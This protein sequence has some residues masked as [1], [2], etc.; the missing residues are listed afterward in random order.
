MQLIISGRHL[1]VTDEMKAH[2]EN[3]L[4]RL[5]GEYPK[6]TTGRVVMDLERNWHV[7]EAHIQGKHVNFDASARTTDMYASIDDAI[8]KLE[9]QLRRYLDRVQ[10]HH[11]DHGAEKEVREELAEAV[12]AEAEGDEEIDE[13]L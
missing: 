8:G 7:V 5:A 13:S 3:G 11:P 12:I 2:A 6:L 1:S 10:D 9:K 4:T